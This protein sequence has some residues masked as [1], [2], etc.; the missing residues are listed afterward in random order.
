VTEACLRVRILPREHQVLGEGARGSDALA[1]GCVDAAI[2][3][4]RAV[5]IRGELKPAEMVGVEEVERG[6]C[7]GRA[8][9]RAASPSGITAPLYPIYPC[10]E[11]C[12]GIV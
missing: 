7:G 10:A 1:K 8:A 2:P 11:P 3:D 9:A 12:D 6:G 5:L 4:D